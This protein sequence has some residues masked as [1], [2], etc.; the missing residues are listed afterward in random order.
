MLVPKDVHDVMFSRPRTASLGY[1]CDEVDSF[2]DEMEAT[3]TA[4]YDE[5]ED[6][7]SRIDE[8]LGA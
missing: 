2:L 5:I 7:R 6:L 1:H 3:L 8:D 4:L